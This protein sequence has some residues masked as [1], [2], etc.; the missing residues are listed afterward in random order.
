MLG[1]VEPF[2][3]VKENLEIVTFTEEKSIKKKQHLLQLWN[4][5]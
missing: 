5:I 2:I 4:S 3:T 1:T